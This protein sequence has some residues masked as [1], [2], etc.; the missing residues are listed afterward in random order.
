ML[1]SGS[2]VAP[3]KSR[4]PVRCH[5]MTASGLTMSSADRQWPQNRESQPIG[6]SQ[7][8][9]DASDDFGWNTPGSIA[10]GGGQELLLAERHGIGS[11]LAERK[12]RPKSLS[13]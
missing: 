10:D 6:H 5:A 3:Q 4:N 7:S 11:N 2:K 12:A 13:F 1:F 8:N 9:G